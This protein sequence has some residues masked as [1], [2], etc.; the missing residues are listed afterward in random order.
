[1]IDD[2]RSENTPSGSAALHLESTLL[3]ADRPLEALALAINEE[4]ALAEQY[5]TM[6]IHRARRVNQIRPDPVDRKRQSAH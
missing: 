2:S 3:A 6:A 4:H 1:M 5:A